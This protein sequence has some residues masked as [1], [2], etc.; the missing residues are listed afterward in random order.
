LFSRFLLLVDMLDGVG[1]GSAWTLAF[2]ALVTLT[3]SLVSSANFS[4]SSAFPRQQ[5]VASLRACLPV[6]RCGG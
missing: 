2:P 4:S 5:I 1:E 6:A 3:C